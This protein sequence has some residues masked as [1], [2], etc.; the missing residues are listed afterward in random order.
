MLIKY[1]LY[2]RIPSVVQ[3]NK[4]NCLGRKYKKQFSMTY[5]R[6]KKVYKSFVTKIKQK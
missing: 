4:V 5:F 3:T 1:L 6:T 2:T